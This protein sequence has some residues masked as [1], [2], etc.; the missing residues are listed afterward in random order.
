MRRCGVDVVVRL[1]VSTA[2]DQPHEDATI[3]VFA[4][5][6]WSSGTSAT[7]ARAGRG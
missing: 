1:H 3:K 2:A 4:L 6:V 5:F 7:S